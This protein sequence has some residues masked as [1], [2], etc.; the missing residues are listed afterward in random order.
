[1]RLKTHTVSQ[2]SLVL[3]LFIMFVG[4]FGSIKDSLIMSLLFSVLLTVWIM[5]LDAITEHILLVCNGFILLI[6]GLGFAYILM[7]RRNKNKMSLHNILNVKH[8]YVL[9]V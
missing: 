5:S 9:N 7:I 1:M 4:L 8:I 6:F 2:N 3:L